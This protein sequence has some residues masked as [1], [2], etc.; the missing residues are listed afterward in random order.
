MCF[1]WAEVVCAV[2]ESAGKSE[3]GCGGLG[4]HYRILHIKNI[5]LFKP[6]KKVW[7]EL[8]KKR[9]GFCCILILGEFAN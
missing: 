9:D 1:A 2:M 3:P 7:S 8:F 4:K 5:T 6:I